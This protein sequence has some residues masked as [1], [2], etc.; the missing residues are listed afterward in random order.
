LNSEI[1][2][3]HL[4]T[5]QLNN[6]RSMTLRGLLI[7]HQID[8]TTVLK[9]TLSTP[10]SMNASSESASSIFSLECNPQ[11]QVVPTLP[12]FGSLISWHSNLPIKL[13]DNEFQWQLEMRKRF[14][15]FYSYGL[16]GI[17]AGIHGKIYSTF[18]TMMTF[19]V[20]LPSISV[21]SMLHCFPSY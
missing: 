7:T 16:P 12:F 19:N 15:D 11:L 6:T 10:A 5:P 1:T 2:L 18:T 8:A 14:G 4:I 17:G 20:K 13:M 9:R 21:F 3:A